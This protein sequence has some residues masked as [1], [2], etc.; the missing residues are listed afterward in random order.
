MEQFA[1][2]PDG[3]DGR[4]LGALHDLSDTRALVDE[5]NRDRVQAHHDR[6][7]TAFK[8]R[9]GTIVRASASG[10]ETAMSPR[11]ACSR[12]CPRSARP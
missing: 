12:A 11:C 3:D 9:S 7:Y 6:L 2:V 4:V 10:S 8:R 1:A 5:Q